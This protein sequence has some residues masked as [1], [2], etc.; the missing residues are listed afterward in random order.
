MSDETNCDNDCDTHVS[1]CDGDTTDN[2]WIEDGVCM[3]DN[4]CKEQVVYILQR[5]ERARRDLL[6]V[7]TCEEL[8]DLANTI[9]SLPTER[10]DDKLMRTFNTGD[11]LPQYTV[12]GGNTNNR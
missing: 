6:R 9:P 12:Y 3:L 11:C 7:T 4:L 8:L 10:D 2:C 5:N 1:L